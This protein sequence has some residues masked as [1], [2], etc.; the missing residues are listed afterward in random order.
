[1]PLGADINTNNVLFRRRD[2]LRQMIDPDFLLPAE[3][4]RQDVLSDE[5]IQRVKRQVTYQERNDV[6]LN[7]V[8][9]KNDIS[10]AVL[11]FYVCLQNTDQHHVCNFI[12]CNGGKRTFYLVCFMSFLMVWDNGS[13]LFLCIVCHAVLLCISLTRCAL[14]TVFLIFSNSNNHHQL[15]QI[16][17]ASRSYCPISVNNWVT[18]FHQSNISDIA[19]YAD[20]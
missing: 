20:L 10:L 12:C 15:T 18:A 17:V 3:L 13:G 6:L 19:E 7:I 16:H 4:V 2:A 8:I 11:R 5:D 14:V 1:V 9:Q